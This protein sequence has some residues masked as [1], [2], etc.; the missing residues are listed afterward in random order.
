SGGVDAAPEKLPASCKSREEDDDV[1][2]SDSSPSIL[3][4]HSL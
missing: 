2:S 4:M 3:S 1:A